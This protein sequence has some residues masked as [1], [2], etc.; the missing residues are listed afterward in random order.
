MYRLRNFRPR[1]THI[2]LAILACGVWVLAIEYYPS[3]MD[4][5]RAATSS[6]SEKALGTFNL[7]RVNVRDA[8]GT[9]RLVISNPQAF[10]RIRVRGKVYPR[11]FRRIKDVAG[12][13]FY[14]S[15]GNETGGLVLSNNGKN[16]HAALVFDYDY[17]PTDGIYMGTDESL[18]GKHWSA[19]FGINDRRPYHPGPIKSSGSVQRISLADTDGDAELVFRD[20]KGRPRIRIGVDKDGE[21]HIQ[22]LNAHGKATHSA[23][24]RSASND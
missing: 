1:V 11:K 16:R 24:N 2:L 8:N 18:N 21:P 22:T 5:T 12:M 9:T 4:A 15:K 6:G 7:H 10:P 23:Q 14:N 13:T 3:S 19:G 20:A 17:Q